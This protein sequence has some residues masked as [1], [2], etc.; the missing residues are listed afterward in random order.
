MAFINF[1]GFLMDFNIMPA[2]GE[3]RFMV[4]GDQVF[5]IDP[6]GRIGIK[7]IT[8]YAVLDQQ[9]WGGGIPPLAD[10]GYCCAND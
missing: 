10:A 2:E 5:I 8:T 6:S 3:Y 9:R 1:D 4:A 7:D